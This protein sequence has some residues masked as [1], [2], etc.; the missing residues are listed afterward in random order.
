[1]IYDALEM[2]Y[3]QVKVRKDPDCAV[4]GENPTVTEL[5]D[6]EAFCGVVSE[7]AQEAAA[8]STITP[9]QLKEWIDGDEKIEIIDVREPNEYEIVAIPG[10]RLIPKNEFLMGNA[11]QDL[12][13]DRRIVLNCKTGCP[14]RRGPRGPQVRGLRRR[15]ARRRR[16]DRLGQPDRAREAGLL[17]HA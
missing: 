11:L 7:E 5:I 8:G 14:Q 12:P 6:Y 3:R 15:G 9:K 13:Q 16:R 10:A 2:Q 17:V 1:M 4:C